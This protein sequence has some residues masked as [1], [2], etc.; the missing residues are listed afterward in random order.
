MSENN[1]QKNKYGKVTIET[2][3]S[4][5]KNKNKDK[6]AKTILLII[7]CLCILLIL[8]SLVAIRNNNKKKANSEAN[9]MEETV[10]TLTRE[11]ST[12]ENLTVDE[13]NDVAKFLRLK[14]N[15][16]FLLSDYSKP[17]EIDLNKAL[18]DG[19]NVGNVTLS[20]NEK[21]EFLKAVDEDDIYTN[22][23][24][25]TSPEI[26][27]FFKTKTGE[28]VGNIGAR[29][30]NT[31]TYLQNYD[32]YYN[33]HGN[34]LYEETTV[35]SGT[36][37]GDRYTV[38]VSLRGGENEITKL[39]TTLKKTG[40]TYMFVSNKIVS[41]AQGTTNSRGTNEINNRAETENV[42]ISAT[43]P[44]DNNSNQN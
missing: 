8:V 19:A 41:E 15:N 24:R 16:G 28:D 36:K 25:L 37:V 11:A 35:E 29:L 26:R 10:D 32:S 13:L 9:K 31:W 5:N 43:I 39:V 4:R 27:T 30:G 21:N 7:I 6:T 12:T 44:L 42:T 20:G 33:E 3:N 17:S 1:E 2:E 14:E 23:V 22:V 18:Y 38:N 40:N 34:A